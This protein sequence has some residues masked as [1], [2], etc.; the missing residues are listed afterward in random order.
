MV[1]DIVATGIRG[2]L[3][4]ICSL[5]VFGQH[6][7]KRW[8]TNFFMSRQSK[9]MGYVTVILRG[10]YRQP[11]DEDCTSVFFNLLKQFTGVRQVSDFLYRLF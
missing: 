5:H 11:S 10:P 3:P 8:S 1:S 9:C 7:P 2:I 6:S 4:F